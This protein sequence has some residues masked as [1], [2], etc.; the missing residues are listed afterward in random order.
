MN[1]PFNPMSMTVEL[2]PDR[3][4]VGQSVSRR[5]DPVLLRGEGRYTDD[6][7][8]PGQLYAVVVRS[9]V[10]H[11]MI[12]GIDTA[13]A[14][15][16]PGVHAVYLAAVLRAGGVKPMQVNVTAQNY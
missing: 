11:G 16:M 5:E 3:F 6:L 7:N 2:A 15:T 13:E 8:L 9:R 14:R 4:A 1:A 12:R 10:A